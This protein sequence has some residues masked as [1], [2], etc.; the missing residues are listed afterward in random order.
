MTTE[1]A[2]YMVRNERETVTGEL[3]YCTMKNAKKHKIFPLFVIDTT[4]DGIVETIT[5]MREQIEWMQ[6]HKAERL[7]KI[8]REMELDALDIKRQKRFF[9]DHFNF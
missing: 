2:I 3:N 1:Y 7:A 9:I 4:A 6:S 8:Q 5:K